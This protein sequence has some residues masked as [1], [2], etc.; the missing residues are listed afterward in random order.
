MSRLGH[1]NDFMRLGHIPK[2]GLPINRLTFNY[3]D[4]TGI[5][6]SLRLVIK[7]YAGFCIRVRRSSDNTTQDIGFVNELVDL[8]SI[9]TFIGVSNGFI[10]RFYCQ[11]STGYFNQST[12]AN[13]PRI[14]ISGVI[15]SYKGLPFIEFTTAGSYR[16]IFNSTFA[17][18]LN[19]ITVIAVGSA[20]AGIIISQAE[21]QPSNS[22]LYIP[23]I[24][25]GVKTIGY[26]NNGAFGN[27]GSAG[28]NMVITGISTNN[29]RVYGYSNLSEFDLGA[30]QN[31]AC[32]G[33][34]ITLGTYYNGT[35]Y[36]NQLNGYVF[37]LI[38]NTSV[39]SKKS[40]IISQL[41]TDLINIL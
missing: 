30:V 15:N 33:S 18:N 29:S 9:Q 10:E 37:E 13:Q 41:Y 3:A 28:L 38:I 11:N 34:L 17:F 32:N 16:M 24:S 40:N 2:N 39:E 36:A 12:T 21:N 26:G 20:D 19:N 31:Q 8:A 22:R 6:C 23:L 4:L 35:I 5:V 25:A 14:A 27:V 7:S 1:I